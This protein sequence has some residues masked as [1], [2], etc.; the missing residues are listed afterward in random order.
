MSHP[1]LR[2]EN[3]CLPPSI[4]DTD[5]TTVKVHQYGVGI[6]CHSTFFEIRILVSQRADLMTNKVRSTPS[7]RN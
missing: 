1:Q 3:C 6:D 2:Q 4:G 5:N 7:G